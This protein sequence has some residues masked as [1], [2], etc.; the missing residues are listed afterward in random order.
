M[1]EGAACLVLES[2]TMAQ[3]RGV[4]DIY[5]EIVGVGA[6]ADAYHCTGLDPSGDHV[7]KCMELAIENGERNT[8][9]EELIHKLGYINAHGTSTEIGYFSILCDL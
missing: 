5:G 2:E 6:T 3:R 9:D 8:G 1:G 4:T 7:Q